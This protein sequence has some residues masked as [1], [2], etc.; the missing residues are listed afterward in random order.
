[1][2]S[3]SS[4]RLSRHHTHSAASTSSRTTESPPLIQTN[5]SESDTVLI[6]TK[7]SNV[8]LAEREEK[9]QLLDRDMETVVKQALIEKQCTRLDLGYNVITSKGA[10]ILADA[11]QYNNT[12]EQLSL[13]NNYIGDTGVDILCTALSMNKN[14]LRKLDLSEN[15]ITDAGAGYLGQMLKNNTILTHLTLSRNNISDEGIEEL[16]NAI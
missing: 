1:M 14:N 5:N 16:A 10:S 3:S 6:A 7:L 12:L 15:D 4:A 8:S 13:W 2:T 9:Q 11:L